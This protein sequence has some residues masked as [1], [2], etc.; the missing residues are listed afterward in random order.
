MFRRVWLAVWCVV[1]GQALQAHEFWMMPN[2]FKISPPDTLNVT[3]MIGEGFDGTSFAFQP[4]AFAK[5]IWAGPDVAM[6]L[7]TRSLADGAVALRP[8]G[9]GLHILAVES[10]AQRHVYPTV[11]AFA[12]FLKETGQAARLEE[13]GFIPPASGPVNER[14]RRLSKTLVHIEGASGQDRR[15]GLPREWVKQGDGFVLYDDGEVRSD[16]P[17]FVFCRDDVSPYAVTV[18]RRQTDQ[19]GR[20]NPVLAPSSQCL[21]STVFTANSSTDGTYQS[22]WVSILFE[23]GSKTSAMRLTKN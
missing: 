7:H 8:L 13:T 16:Q 14:Y 1:L 5:A 6:E 19:D 23:S 20:I 2:Q 4:R 21:I 22:D 15:V 18:Q 9:S 17:A 10:F 12:A 3:V 11:D